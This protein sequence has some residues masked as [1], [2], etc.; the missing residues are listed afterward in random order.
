MNATIKDI[1]IVKPIISVALHLPKK[2]NITKTT[3]NNE[4]NI[5][6]CKE[7]IEF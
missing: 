4:Y 5:D 3:K 2:N 7:S 1:G 6:Y